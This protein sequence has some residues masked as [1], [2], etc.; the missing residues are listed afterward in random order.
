MQ[1]VNARHKVVLQFM[2]IKILKKPADW[3]V[4]KFNAGKPIY[5][6]VDCE[7]G[8]DQN[9]INTSTSTIHA[10]R[11]RSVRYESPEKVSIRAGVFRK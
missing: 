11:A 9:Q 8:D 2:R 1:V 4:V 7:Q 6:P 10:V 5:N 3:G